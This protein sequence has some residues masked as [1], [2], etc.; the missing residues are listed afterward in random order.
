M[1]RGEL[2]YLRCLKRVF[3]RETEK[4]L[5]L[6]VRPKPKWLPGPLWH[7]FIKKLIRIQMMPLPWS[8]VNNPQYPGK[9]KA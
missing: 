1:E 5:A 7:W 4:R 8:S 2:F 6:V 3:T 9:E